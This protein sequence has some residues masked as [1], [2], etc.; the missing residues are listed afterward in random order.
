MGVRNMTQIKEFRKIERIVKGFANHRRLEIL[1]LL[2]RKPELSVD[3]IAEQLN[4]GYMNA[5]DH[6]RKMLI[7]GLIIKRSD[8]PYVRHKIT[9]RAAIILAFCKKLE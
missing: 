7:A 3:E 6:L 9:T 4:I 1:D 2:E 5:S 8:G